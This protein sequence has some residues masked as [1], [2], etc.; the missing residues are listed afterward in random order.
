MNRGG[1][2]I[3]KTGSTR[4]RRALMKKLHELLSA[5]RNRQDLLIETLADP[6]DS[7]RSTA[8]RELAVD[9]LDHQA[10]L[11]HEVE[12]ALESIGDGSYGMCERCE[13]AI[14]VAR[15][16]AVPW[17]RL[18]VKCQSQKEATER[19]ALAFSRAA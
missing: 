5:V 19:P 18:C 7:V 6:L 13:Q 3:T 4:H 10:R 2:A 11:I 12:S 9:R 8:E 17:A 14:P 1:T 16:N 15:L